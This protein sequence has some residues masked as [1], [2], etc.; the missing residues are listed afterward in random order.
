M[1]SR[2]NLLI[3]LLALLAAV[4][5]G[6]LQHRS[7]LAQV[8]DGVHV[9]NVGDLRPDLALLDLHGKEHRLSEFRGQRVLINFWASWCV[10]CLAE[11]PALDAAQR[12]FGDQGAIVLGIAMDDPSRVQAF[13]AAHPVA[14]PVLLGELDSPSTSLRLGDTEEVLPF[15]VL[16]DGQGRVIASHRGALDAAQLARWLSPAT[17]P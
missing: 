7:R 1:L 13:L 16:L 5:G 14:Y 2:G 12:K 15:S 3:L 10:P 11:M 8:P 4:A 9:A 17:A 6:W